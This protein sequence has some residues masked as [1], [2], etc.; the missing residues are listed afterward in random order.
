M[1][2]CSLAAAMRRSFAAISGRRSSKAAGITPGI[3]GITCEAWHQR[4]RRQSKLG[5]RLADQ[6]RDGMFILRS[7]DFDVGALHPG[8]VELRS[9]FCHIG[10]GRRA[11]LEA[12]LGELQLRS[13]KP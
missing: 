3:S 6:H 2:I 13:R 12:I 7:L 1:P 4:K 8:L 9:G 11:A 10:L 5:R